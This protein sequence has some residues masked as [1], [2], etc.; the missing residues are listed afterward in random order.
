[1]DCQGKSTK[2]SP[3][4]TNAHHFHIRSDGTDVDPN[5]TVVS[6]QK[7]DSGNVKS[8]E[9]LKPRIPACSSQSTTTLNFY[10]KPLPD[11]CIGFGSDAGINL[12]KSAM[13]HEFMNIYFLLGPQ[14]RTQDEPA[15][16]GLTS[17][18]MVLNAFAVDPGVVWKGVWRWYHEDMLDCCAKLAKIKQR[19][20]TASQ[21]TCA[22]RCNQLE[23]EHVNVTHHS[24]IDVFRE[25]VKQSCAGNGSCIICSFN[26][27]VLQ[28]T[29][30]GHFS[31]IGGYHPVEDCLLILETARFKYP[32][33]WVRL[34]KIWE[35]M[36]S[37]D[38]ETGAPRGY[39]ILTKSNRQPSLMWKISS[40][41]NIFA[42][43]RQSFNHLFAQIIQFLRSD[44]DATK[45]RDEQ[46]LKVADKI[47]QLSTTCNSS[48]EYLLRIRSFGKNIQKLSLEHQGALEELI[49]AIEKTR[50]FHLFY[51][52]CVGKRKINLYEDQQRLFNPFEGIDVLQGCALSTEQSPSQVFTRRSS[53]AAFTSPYCLA[54][55]IHML[56]AL[57]SLTGK[58]QSF[59]LSRSYL[60]AINDY[61]AKDMATAAQAAGTYETLMAAQ[62]PSIPGPSR[63]S[64]SLLSL[65]SNPIKVRDVPSATDRSN[66]VVGDLIGWQMFYNEVS[67]LQEQLSQVF[68]CHPI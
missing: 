58:N 14:L 54:M 66:R 16:C 37:V 19:G 40:D 28:Q 26:R 61:V 9:K 29:G 60:G 44:F 33:Y 34:E 47:L 46:M 56:P 18:V 8:S 52:N 50:A 13:Q 12:F 10:R 45:S 15:Y 42:D 4:G 64:Y 38:T 68:I 7:L 2:L 27:A 30:T 59:N 51:S 39:I 57:E 25:R 67:E 6:S 24:S 21:L 41:Y 53:V 43:V 3:T 23:A 32:P 20:I 35:A 1:M 63:I 62:G 65:N 48:M 5:S 55:L 49:C 36:N 17:L 22:A 11:S 31:P